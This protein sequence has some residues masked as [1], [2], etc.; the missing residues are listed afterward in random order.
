VIHGYH[1]VIVALSLIQ[2]RE[3]KGEWGLRLPRSQCSRCSRYRLTPAGVLFRPRGTW[4]LAITESKIGG[5]GFSCTHHH[6]LFLGSERS[7]P[8]AESV[9]PGRDTVDREVVRVLHS[10]AEVLNGPICKVSDH[11]CAVRAAGETPV[12]RG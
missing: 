4:E 12:H 6:V 2:P 11:A 8:N 10:Q 3:V 9:V 5:R 1:K 7:R